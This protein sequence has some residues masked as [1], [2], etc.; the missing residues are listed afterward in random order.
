[1][2]NAAGETA[3]L[4]AVAADDPQVAGIAE[5]NLRFAQ[6]RLLQEQRLVPLR[7]GRTG[8]EG[9]GQRGQEMSHGRRLLEWVQQGLPSRN[10]VQDWFP[11]TRLPGFG[12]EDWTPGTSSGSPRIIG[13]EG[14]VVSEPRSSDS[15]PTCDGRRSLYAEGVRQRSPGSRSAPWDPGA[16]KPTY[17]EGV[18][19][20]RGW[21]LCNPFGVDGRVCG[22]CPGC[23]ARPWAGVSN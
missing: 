9:E 17:P 1:Q 2:A 10:G 12:T 19:Q 18:A 14:C 21:S 4:P 3:G 20:G 13:V 23:A 11:S 5:G 6:S 8:G 7:T 22:L 16:D 15:V